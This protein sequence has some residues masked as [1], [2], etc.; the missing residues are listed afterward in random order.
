MLQLDWLTA[1]YVKVIKKTYHTWG[2]HRK[3]VY[4]QN[5]HSDLYRERFYEFFFMN[6]NTSFWNHFVPFL[7]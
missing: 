2:L 7:P 3:T 6:L 1:F 4:V 5:F